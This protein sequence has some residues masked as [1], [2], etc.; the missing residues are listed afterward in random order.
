MTPEGSKRTRVSETLRL[1]AK[2]TS[3]REGCHGKRA[4]GLCAFKVRGA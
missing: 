1:G 4:N 2:D 3:K